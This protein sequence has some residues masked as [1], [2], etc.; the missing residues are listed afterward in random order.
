MFLILFWQSHCS[1]LVYEPLIFIFVNCN[2]L[3]LV[4]H[5]RHYRYS[6]NLQLHQRFY[7]SW[8]IPTSI[9][10]YFIL[11][12]W[13]SPLLDSSFISTS[14]SHNLAHHNSMLLLGRPI[15][16]FRVFDHFF[17]PITQSFD[18]FSLSIINAATKNVYSL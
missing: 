3:F 13:P 11:E 7:V 12:A 6:L 15:K 10:Y 9:N 16:F 18:S 17:P 5:H 1:R 14:K 8:A 4:Y 2:L